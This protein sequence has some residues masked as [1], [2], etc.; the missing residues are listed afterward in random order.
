MLGGRIGAM[1]SNVLTH[2]LML[3]LLA[4]TVSFLLKRFAK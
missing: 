2:W 4:A 1:E 3:A